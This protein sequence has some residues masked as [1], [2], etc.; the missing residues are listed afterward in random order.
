[1]AKDFAV[2]GVFLYKEHK[3]NTLMKI[4]KH[5]A[6]GLL[7]VSLT[8]VWGQ[9]VHTIDVKTGLPVTPNESNKLAKFNLDFP[10]GTPT[11]LIKA[12]EKAKGKPLNAII[13]DEYANE[14]LPPLKMSNVDVPRLFQALKMASVKQVQYVTG[15]Y[16]GGMGGPSS[17]YSTLSSSYGFKTEGPETDDS[18]WYFFEDKPPQRPSSPAKSCR[19]YQLSSYLDHGLTVDDITT[20]IQTGWKMM[21]DTS[22]PE[23][24]FHKETKL[25]IA[26][27]EPDKLDVIDNVLKALQPAPQTPGADFQDRLKQIIKNQ[28]QSQ[29]S[30]PAAPPT[31][32][33]RRMPPIAKPPD[34]PADRQ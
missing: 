18:V 13:P 27:G 12:I 24:S 26:V 5:L 19:F 17:T 32:P 3:P 33:Q 25:L 16:F 6:L 8:P 9:E 29:A 28:N 10:G 21:G 31:I 30:V 1:L 22:P 11:Q 34:F 4:S 7:V 23:I 15:P 14:Q 2:A 20:A